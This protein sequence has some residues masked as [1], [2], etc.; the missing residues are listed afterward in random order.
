MRGS[1][2]GWSAAVWVLAFALLILDVAV[3]TYNIDALV[4]NDRAVAHSRD[5][6]RAM[7]DLVSAL[8]DAETGQRGFHITGRDEYLDPFRAAEGA[9]PRHLGRLAELT[10]GDPFYD[11]RVARVS[12]LVDRRF[13]QMRRTIALH[14]QA[15]GWD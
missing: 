10:D 4:A 11:D 3:S 12:A 1:L 7:S 2:S 8:K 5:V 15:D 13:A 6:S 9:V 14:R